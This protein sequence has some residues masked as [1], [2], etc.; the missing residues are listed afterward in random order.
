MPDMQVQWAGHR[1][2]STEA[3]LGPATRMCHSF[4][5]SKLEEAEPTSR[6]LRRRRVQ[7]LGST[8]PGSNPCAEVPTP[9]P[10]KEAVSTSA[11]P[12]VAVPLPLRGGEIVGKTKLNDGKLYRQRCASVKPPSS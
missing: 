5:I 6:S 10:H 1:R 12:P 2:G 8:A 9:N 11:R 3:C 4:L 7:A